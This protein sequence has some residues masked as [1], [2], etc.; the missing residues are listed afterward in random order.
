MT[1]KHELQL[2]D[3]ICEEVKYLYKKAYSKG[4]PRRLGNGSRLKDISILPNV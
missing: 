4:Y 2:N 3:R 1:I